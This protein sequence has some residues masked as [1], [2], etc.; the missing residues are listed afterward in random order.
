MKATLLLLSLG[1]LSLPAAAQRNRVTKATVYTDVDGSV[2]SHQAYRS[3]LVSGQFVENNAQVSNHLIT[4]ISLRPA[5]APD[6]VR[7]EASS[8]ARA[9]HTSAP[10][11]ALPDLNGQLYDLAALRGK[12]VVLNF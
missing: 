11:F 8:P 5:P 4:S 9:Y 12:V 3:K 10:A 2:L 7:T 1:L 6:S